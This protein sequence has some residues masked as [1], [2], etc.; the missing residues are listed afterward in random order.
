MTPQDD[1]PMVLAALCV[2]REARGEAYSAMLG[3]ACVLRNLLAVEGDLVRVITR[4]DQF[5]SMTFHGD[6]NLIEWPQAQDGAFRMCSMA[7]SSILGSLSPDITGGATYYFSPP[8]EEPPPGWGPVT[9]TVTLGHLTFCR[10]SKTDDG[11]ER[12]AKESQAD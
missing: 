1:Y 9:V 5:S 12:P 8:L 7:V 4:R 10:S 2:W 3:V 11:T 6:P